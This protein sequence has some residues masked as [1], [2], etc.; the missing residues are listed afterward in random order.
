MKTKKSTEKK[1]KEKLLKRNPTKV[2][3]AADYVSTGSTLLN[4]AISGNPY[5]GFAKGH[6]YR[7]VGD[8]ASGKTWLC[9]TCFAEAM[10]NPNFQNHRIIY[11]DVEGGALMDMG[12]FFGNTVAGKIEP[13]R[14]KDGE[15]VHSYFIEDFYYH[16]DDAFKDGRPFIYVLDSMDGLT[17]IAEETKFDENKEAYRKG[18]KQTGSYGDKAKK[19]SGDM[20]KVIGR[21]KKTESILIVISQTRDNLS[22]MSMAKKTCSGGHSLLFYAG[23][24]IWSSIKGPI[25]KTVKGK[26]R[27]LGVLC[28]LRVKK[29]RVTGRDR[30]VYVPLYHS[31]GIDDVGGVCAYLIDEGHW[32]ETSGGIAAPEMDFTGKQEAL[33]HHIEEKGLEQDLRAIAAEVWNDIEEACTVA[34]KPRYA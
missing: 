16:V 11:D 10:Q 17:S 15:P 7:F 14:M 29:N 9:L 1:I 6:Y 5:Q 2:L 18:R 28:K 30:T 20:H 25:E 3:T 13:P 21:L 12:R 19:N 33:V 26:K 32:K 31:F 8:S 34:R 23:L 27:Q 4:L 22:P 24:E